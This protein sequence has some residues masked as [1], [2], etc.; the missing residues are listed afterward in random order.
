MYNPDLP[1]SNNGQTWSIE[2][3]QVGQ[4]LDR[5]LMSVLNTL[6]R[7]GIQQLIV[8]G[9]V[10]VNGRTSKSGYALKIHDEVQVQ[11][12]I[13][14]LQ[15]KDIKP[16]LLPLDIMYEDDDLFIVNK[17]AGMVVHPAVGHHDDTLC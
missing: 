11:L 4:R 13:P 14:A 9:S 6:S 2:Q 16:Q 10:L 8:E 15:P 7:T 12:A 3:D 1:L 5:Y 17:V